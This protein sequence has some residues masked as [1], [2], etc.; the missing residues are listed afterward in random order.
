MNVKWADGLLRVATLF[1]TL[2]SLDA[3]P[4]GR[5]ARKIGEGYRETEAPR[6]DKTRKAA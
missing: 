3:I 4:G 6:P 5:I 2:D 1:D